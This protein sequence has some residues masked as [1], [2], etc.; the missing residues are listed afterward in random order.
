[1]SKLKRL[2]TFRVSMEIIDSG[3]SA[4]VLAYI[5]ATVVKAECLYGYDCV[6]YTAHSSAF[7]E[8]SEGM[9]IPRYELVI[10]QDELLNIIDVSAKLY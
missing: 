6:E 9:E 1:M 3:F 10:K 7:N 2:G 8:V 5:K 4:H